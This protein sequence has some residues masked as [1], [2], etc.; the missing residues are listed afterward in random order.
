MGNDYSAGKA[1][2][3]GAVAFLSKPFEDE[4]LLDKIRAALE[5]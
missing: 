3:A 5:D 2:T 4:I 1:M